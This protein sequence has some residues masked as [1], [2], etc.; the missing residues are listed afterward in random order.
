MYYLLDAVPGPV[1]WL[2]KDHQQTYW[3]QHNIW[4]D[5]G[6]P[7]QE[8]LIPAPLKFDLQPIKGTWDHGP[9]MPQYLRGERMPIFR[10]DVVAAMKAAGVSNI[11]TYEVEITD[12]ESGKVYTNY[13]AVNIIGLIAAADMSE[14][15][16]EVHDNIPLVDVS[17]DTLVLDESKTRD[18][19]IFRMAENN[20]S[21]LVH[22]KLKK[23]LG[24]QGIKNL[25][26]HE[27]ETVGIL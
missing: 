19:L 22:E 3:R 18:T 23:S 2:G 11:D 7:F 8:G 24:A 26:F 10:D 12:P 17:F 4:W 6:A 5:N 27:L 16:A 14:S 25:K 1:R 20:S 9:H 13:K 15:K 21:I